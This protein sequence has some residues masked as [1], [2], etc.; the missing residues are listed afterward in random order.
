MVVVTLITYSVTGFKKSAGA[1]AP[2]SVQMNE[3]VVPVLI[4]LLLVN[5]FV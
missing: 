4:E 5:A 2:L 1:E 3:T